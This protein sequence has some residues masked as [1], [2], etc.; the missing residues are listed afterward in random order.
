ML[1]N[2]PGVSHVHWWAQQPDADLIEKCTEI[3]WEYTQGLRVSLSQK[4]IIAALAVWA[5][6][7]QMWWVFRTCFQSI[8]LL[9]LCSPFVSVLID[10]NIP[11][12]DWSKFLGDESH[13]LRSDTGTWR[14]REWRARICYGISWVLTLLKL[15]ICA[16]GT[17]LDRGAIV[18]VLS[19]EGLLKPMCAWGI[20]SDMF[21]FN[22]KKKLHPSGFSDQQHR[23]LAEGILGAVFL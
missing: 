14:D 5:R 7:Y 6:R 22:I 10:A 12:A 15:W 11:G 1:P 13:C 18:E 17:G 2:I 23:L 21:L 9:M 19:S 3:V 16:Q 20:F 8:I 4:T